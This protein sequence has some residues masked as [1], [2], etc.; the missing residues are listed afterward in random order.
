VT[1]S[2]AMRV[3]NLGA[4]P[5]RAVTFLLCEI[6]TVLK[7]GFYSGNVGRFAES[8]KAV[9]IGYFVDLNNNINW[10]RV[11]ASV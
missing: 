8:L 5:S 3:K 10:R 9:G 11:S 4:L 1:L 2:K 6:A 7:L